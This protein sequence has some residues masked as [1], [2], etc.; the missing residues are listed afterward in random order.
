MAKCFDLALALLPFEPPFFEKYGLRCEFVGHPVLERKARM[1]GGPALRERLGISLETPLLVVLPGSRTSEIRFILPVF[2]HALEVLAHRVP[3]LVTVLPT[4]PHLAARVHHASQSWP[5]PLH[6]VENEDDKYA[7]FDAA[8]AALAASGTVTTELAL[9]RTPMVAAYRVGG[10][11]YLLAKPFFRLPHF[12]LVNL[13]LN[14]PAVP[15]FLQH[16]ATPNALADAVTP[17]LIDKE[18]AARQIADLDEAAERLGAGGDAPSLRAA[19]ALIAF[20]QSGAG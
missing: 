11:T 3:G 7:A 10:L 8:N 4:L 2:K 12:T 20:A 19:R 6:I 17:L 16:Y 1:G 9:A 14:K 5:T 13:L 15:E 18:A